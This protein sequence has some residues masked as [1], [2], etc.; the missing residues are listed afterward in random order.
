MKKN[1]K[2]VKKIVAIS[3][4]IICVMI[5]AVVVLAHNNEIFKP[6][7]PSPSAIW[8]VEFTSIAEGEKVGKATSRKL[9]EYT[10]TSASF[11]VDLVMPGDSIIYDLQVS[12]LGNLDS[13]LNNIEII[14]SPNKEAIKYEIIDIK[15][16]DSLLA[17][18]VKNFQVKVSYILDAEEA[19][20]F[21][22]PIS[23]VFDFR[24]AY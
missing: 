6:T 1:Q 12:N 24:Q 13:V 2:Q 20:T 11:Y 19:V 7:K 21:N 15:E 22:K 8:K 9:P 14:T 10:G 16:G 17:G 23:I 5:T 3:L 4:V 18:E